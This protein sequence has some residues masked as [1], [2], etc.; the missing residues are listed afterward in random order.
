[1]DY[2]VHIFNRFCNKN[3]FFIELNQNM[4]NKSLQR[5]YNIK[6]R[7]KKDISKNNFNKKYQIKCMI[8]YKFIKKFCEALDINNYKLCWRIYEN[9]LKINEGDYYWCKDCDKPMQFIND[10]RYIMY[11]Y[12]S[13]K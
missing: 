7:I 3:N 12:F 4:M 2:C 5:I 6:V 11:C 13:K 9:G 10:R 8:E 1:M